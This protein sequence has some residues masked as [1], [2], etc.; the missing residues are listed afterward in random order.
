M[1]I[2][3][4]VRKWHTL[5]LISLID[6]A[7][8]LEI[9]LKLWVRRTL[10]GILFAFSCFSKNTLLNV[11]CQFSDFFYLVVDEVSS[12]YRNEDRCYII[13]LMCATYSQRN[14]VSASIY[15]C[16]CFRRN[17]NIFE[18]INVITH[19]ITLILYL[20]RLK[21][22]YIVLF[23]WVPKG[24][25]WKKPPTT[26]PHAPRKKSVVKQ[27]SRETNYVA[28]II[29]AKCGFTKSPLRIYCSQLLFHLYICSW[30]WISLRSVL[31]LEDSFFF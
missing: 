9:I 16:G 25:I 31:F 15:I 14:R 17:S 26:Q 30:V 20:E 8:F 6:C 24:E 28:R 10:P 22:W 18:T 21:Y 12:F 27:F 11:L 5:K 23:Y 1:S 29:L 19:I 3:F 2:G 13:L 4:G 7:W